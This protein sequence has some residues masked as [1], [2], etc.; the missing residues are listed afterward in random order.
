MSGPRGQSKT[1]PN[2]P[3]PEPEERPWSAL[4]LKT[5]HDFRIF[6]ALRGV[7][8]YRMLIYPNLLIIQI[9]PRYFSTIYNEYEKKPPHVTWIVEPIPMWRH[10]LRMQVFEDRLGAARTVEGEGYGVIYRDSKDGGS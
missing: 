3:L 6:F 9:H 10:V 5:R 8:A 1:N 7:P 4:P 2:R